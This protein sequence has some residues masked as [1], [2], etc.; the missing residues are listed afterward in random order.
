MS[1]IH[2]IAYH[3]TG[4]IPM[5][6]HRH[7]DYD[8]LELIQVLDGGGNALIGDQMHPLL[9]GTLLLIDSSN[10]HAIHP[11]SDT[12]YCRNKLL[13]GKHALS[14][15]LASI[16]AAQ[17]LKPFTLHGGC[18]FVP[19]PKTSASM[20]HVF[21]HL[22][23]SPDNSTALWAILQLIHLAQTTAAEE[24][25]R[26][27][28]RIQAVLQYINRHYAEPLTTQQIA[29]D[30]MLSKYYLCHLFREHT[31]M[32]LMQYLNEQRL[33]A[34]RKLLIQTDHP[35]LEIAQD[36]GFTTA[37]HFCAF[38]HKQEGLSPR[39]FRK[40]HRFPNLIIP[41]PEAPWAPH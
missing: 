2:E 28:P 35:I 30:T 41:P 6:H 40:K 33:A 14:Q 17:I 31:G 37:A 29:R 10:V 36:C 15:A 16:D 24:T 27:D 21:H 9:P 19:D 39:E 23:R 32:T 18:S 8:A 22:Y 25:P 4:R 3:Q 7:T 12:A 34:A 20:D 13:V 1:F 5:V 26:T 11:D 38:F